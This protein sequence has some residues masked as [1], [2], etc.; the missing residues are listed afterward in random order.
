M[1]CAIQIKR[2]NGEPVK[3]CTDCKN[4]ITPPTSDDMGRVDRRCAIAVYVV[5]G[6]MASCEVARANN[7]LCG[8]GGRFWE[9]KE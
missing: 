4:H 2:P 9:A 1:M 7:D 5:T 3:L 6:F 8:A